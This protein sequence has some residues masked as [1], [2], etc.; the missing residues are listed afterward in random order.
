MTNYL[1]KKILQRLR[2]AFPNQE[3]MLTDG[4]GTLIVY[5]LYAAFGFMLLPFI[6]SNKWFC[7]VDFSQT[8]QIGDTIGG[9]M[10]PFIALLAAFLTF[11]A[12]WIQYRA[13][14]KQKEMLSKQLELAVQQ[15]EMVAK[16][17]GIA[18]K[19]MR[20]A[21]EQ[22]MKYAVERFENT[23]QQMLNVYAKNSE[24]V[25]V[26]ELTGK[27]AFDEMAAELVYI[28][29]VLDQLLKNLSENRSFLKIKQ[30]GQ[31]DVAERQL[32]IFSK[33]SN[34]KRLF[35]MNLSYALFFTG[36]YTKDKDSILSDIAG[37]LLENELYW[38]LKDIIFTKDPTNTYKSKLM[39]L[40]NTDVVAYRAPYAMAEGH[41]SVLGHY[42]RQLFQIVRFISEAPAK[43]FSEEQKYE[44][45]KL[46]RSQMCDAEQILL[47]YNSTS[48]W[49]KVWRE[50]H[51]DNL[52]EVS[53][54]SY[55]IRYRIIKN[56]P[57]NYPFF[58]VSPTNYYHD[59]IKR[60]EA[61][62]GR[63]FFETDV[64][65]ANGDMVK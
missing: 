58:G 22:E 26:G 60:W 42:Y 47:Y 24:A 27:A 62:F 53:S 2:D 30:S 43:M 28:Y 16:Q 4:L 38:R 31:K 37:S 41:N 14:E 25:K 18:E 51:G 6:M 45:V 36:S 49:G 19:Q 34:R 10:G 52:D 8:G 15:N 46:V 12:F 35:L 17:T 48:V 13:N 20:M 1:R 50:Q 54:W 64:F 63:N 33:D 65:G 55:I 9:V 23:L 57:S 7:L 5:F 56:I 11:L 29:R 44:Y 39:A 61:M 32:D 3:D 59:D 21:E 40:G